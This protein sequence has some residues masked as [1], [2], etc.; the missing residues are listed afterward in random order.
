MW[1]LLGFLL[2]WYMFTDSGIQ[3]GGII[4]K[5]SKEELLLVQNARTGLWGFP[6][7]TYESED[8]AYYF[9]AIRE[10]EEETTFRLHQDYTL[11][12]GSCRYGKRMYFYG[13]LNEGTQNIP[14]INTVFANE[15]RAIGWF[16]RNNLPPN[17]NRDMIDWVS[18]GMPDRCYIH[19]DL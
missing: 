7:G 11:E 17:K 2:G 1:F 3:G 13:S 8:M 14:R 15:H 10:M 5:N 18:D 6:K 4:L 9:T 16:H 19:D 12:P